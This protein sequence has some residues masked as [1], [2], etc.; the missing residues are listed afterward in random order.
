MWEPRD[1]ALPMR[2]VIAEA[3][4]AASMCWE[5]PEGAGLFDEKRA[6]EVIDGVMYQ[7]LMRDADIAGGVKPPKFGDRVRLLTAANPDEVMIFLTR[8]RD[9]RAWL[10]QRNGYCFYADEEKLRFVHGKPSG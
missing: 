3:V 10:A 1:N 9:G 8:T 6:T 4:G 2:E 7:L 5:N